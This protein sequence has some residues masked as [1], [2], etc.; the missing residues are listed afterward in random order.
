MGQ[1]SIPT[2][3]EVTSPFS[4]AV[5]LFTSVTCKR[6]SA[7]ITNMLCK[8][9]QVHTSLSLQIIH[10]CFYSTFNTASC[11]RSKAYGKENQY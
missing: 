5:S 4:I 7:A 3:A 9:L 1:N 8:V 6:C 11:V 10:K 2:R